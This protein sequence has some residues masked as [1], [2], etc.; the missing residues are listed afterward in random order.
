MGNQCC[1]IGD[2]E[3]K[4]KADLELRGVSVHEFANNFIDLVHAKYPDSAAERIE[5]KE[6]FIDI[7]LS[8]D[9][10]E[11]G[12]TRSKEEDLDLLGVS[13]HHLANYF[14]DL[15]RAKYPDSGNDTKIYQIEDLNDLD[16]NGIIREEGKDTQCPIDDRRGA[17]YVHTLQ[18]ADHVGPASIMLSYTWGYTIGDIIDVLRNYC[19]S[20]GLNP[21]KVYVWICCLCVNQ[22]RVVE[23]MKRKEDIP[24]DDF[25]KVF[26]GRVTSIGHVVAMMSPW[27]GPEYLKRVWCIFELFTAS[28]E[29][30]KVTI[31]MPKREREDFIKG[32]ANGEEHTNKLFSV[33]SSTDVEKAEA[34]VLSDRENILNIVKNETGGYDQFNV[35]INGLIRTWVLQ[36]IKD[37]AQSR[38]EDLVDGEYDE[39]CTVFLARV[40]IL[41]W[42]LGELETALKMYRVELM[43]VEEKF[44]SDHL[45]MTY[46]LN[47]I[48]LVLRGQGKYEEALGYYMKALIVKEKEYGRESVE[49]A[50]TLHNMGTAYQSQGE[51]GKAIDTYNRALVIKEEKLGLDHIETAGIHMNIASVLRNHKK[52]D[53]SMEKYTKVLPI[54]KK[55]YGH[56]SVNMAT[57]LYNMAITLYNQGKYEDAMENYQLS[58]PIQEKLLGMDNQDTVNTR[59]NIA[60]LKEE[61]QTK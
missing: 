38:L 40:G 30:C 46:P 50:R 52:Y 48:A 14:M 7:L 13:V 10:E 19:T 31:E 47:N 24:F 57:L 8:H 25:R 5:A 1:S 56:D 4:R 2:P 12:L 28:K 9:W 53:E 20:N 60:I 43:M 49:V 44:G 36:L 39:R 59:N 41:F 11:T 34:S 45:R 23:S 33:L 42:R 21:K 17:A 61:M 37:A 32:L 55:A 29:G 16:K 6:K 58:L 26:H 22:H 18:G 35:A 27:T 3:K 15:V 54:Y 51:Y